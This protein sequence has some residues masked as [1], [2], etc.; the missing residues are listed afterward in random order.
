MENINEVLEFYNAGA[1]KGRLEK[2][3]GKVELYRTKEIL[4]NILP[5]LIIQFTTLVEALE[6]ILRGFQS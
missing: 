1:E 5:I 3:L 6:F 4:K 2:G